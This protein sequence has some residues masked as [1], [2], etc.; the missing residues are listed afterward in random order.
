MVLVEEEMQLH[1][2]HHDAQQ[3]HD[4]RYRHKSEV[5]EIAMGHLG[6]AMEPFRS[7]ESGHW[8]CGGT[9]GTGGACELMYEVVSTLVNLA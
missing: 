6:V 9:G 1:Y 4:A 7:G 2:A 5:I 8:S 3:G